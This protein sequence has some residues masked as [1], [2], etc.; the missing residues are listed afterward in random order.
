MIAGNRYFSRIL[1]M[2]IGIGTPG[3]NRPE[4]LLDEESRRG[5][6]VKTDRFDGADAP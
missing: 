6:L 2:T 3:R 5:R 1:V 4:W